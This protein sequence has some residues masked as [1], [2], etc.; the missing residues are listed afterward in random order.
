MYAH[1]C[2]ES[3]HGLRPVRVHAPYG[4]PRWAACKG[5]RYY[6]PDFTTREDC[7]AWIAEHGAAA[8]EADR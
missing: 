6:G 8:L 5:C 2:D 3:C 1:L 7:A 4:G